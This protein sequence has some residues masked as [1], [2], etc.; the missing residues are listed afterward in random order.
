MSHKFGRNCLEAEN[1]GTKRKGNHFVKRGR[2]YSPL[3]LF[4]QNLVC[5]H[6]IEGFL[7]LQ[8]IFKNQFRIKML[9][10][11]YIF[12]DIVVSP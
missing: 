7:P 12:V 4:Y 8:I 5:L 2:H 3:S 9:N 6:E 1:Q 10:K 11:H